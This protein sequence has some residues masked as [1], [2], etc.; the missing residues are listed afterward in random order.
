MRGETNR[1]FARSIG[2]TEN[3]TCQVLRGRVRPSARFR[4][5]AAAHLD[6]PD[7]ALFRD[8]EPGRGAA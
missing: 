2:Y 1:D 5:A 3:W 8:D 4:Q 6:L 7:A